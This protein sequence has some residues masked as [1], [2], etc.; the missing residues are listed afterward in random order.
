MYRENAT[1]C[2]MGLWMK[3]CCFPTFVFSE[4]TLRQFFVTKFAQKGHRFSRG[5][6][7]NKSNESLSFAIDGDDVVFVH[8]VDGSFETLF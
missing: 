5:F 7:V 3:R 4:E 2:L 6:N 8:K 1:F